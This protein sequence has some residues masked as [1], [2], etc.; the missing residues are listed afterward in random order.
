MDPYI[1]VHAR[2]HLLSA[3]PWISEDRLFESE[4]RGQGGLRK[5][6]ERDNIQSSS[7]IHPCNQNNKPKNFNSDRMGVWGVVRVETVK[8]KRDGIQ[9]RSFIQPCDQNNKNQI[10]I[11]HWEQQ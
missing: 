11:L 5:K 4:R 1:Q 8:E 10:R 6:R 9:S 7:F 3:V 2:R